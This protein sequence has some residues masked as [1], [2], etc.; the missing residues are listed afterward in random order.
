MK[1][2]P[3]PR[4]ERLPKWA[5]ADLNRLRADLASARQEIADLVPTENGPAALAALALPATDDYGGKPIP[6]NSV[7]IVNHQRGRVW[8]RIRVRRTDTG[9]EINGDRPVQITASASNDFR[10]DVQEWK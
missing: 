7:F 9:I 10:I 1:H 3:D 4:E 2:T 5:Q 6:T 8:A